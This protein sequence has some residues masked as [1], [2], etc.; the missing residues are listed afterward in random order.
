MSNKV[1]LI[2]EDGKYSV[3]I[4]EAVVSTDKD[5]DK[6]VEKFKQVVNNN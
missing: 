5:I 6:S 3:C 4:N 2:Y 1:T